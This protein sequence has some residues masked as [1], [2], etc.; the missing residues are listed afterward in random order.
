MPPLSLTHTHTL[1]PLPLVVKVKVRLQS[2]ALSFDSHAGPL[3][4]ARDAWRCEG[5]RAFFQGLT[6]RLATCVTRSMS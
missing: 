6:P 1:P 2:R 4:L 5:G 3:A